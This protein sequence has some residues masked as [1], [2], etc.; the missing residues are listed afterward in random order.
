MK[1]NIYSVFDE[2]SG[3]YSQ[4]NTGT[5]D[6]EAVRTFQDMAID[7]KHQVGKHPGDYTLLRLG[8]FDD[9]TGTLTNEVNSTLSTG[10]E[11]RAA[12]KQ[13]NYDLFNK[14]QEQ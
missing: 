1:H 6:G 2:A 5:S 10:L 9:T 13:E 3:L 11:A 7:P 12:Q 8:I 14:D 4:P